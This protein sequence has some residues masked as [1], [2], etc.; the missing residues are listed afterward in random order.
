MVNRNLKMYSGSIYPNIFAVFEELKSK[1]W[2]GF[3]HSAPSFEVMEFSDS[4]IIAVPMPMSPLYRGENEYHE[5]CKPSLYRKEW[6]ELE[7]LKRELLLADFS[8]ILDTHP[9][10][11][12]L[13][14]GGL[15]VN[16]AG[17][18]QHYGIDTHLLDLT[19]SPLVAA[20]FATTEYN[21]L[22]DTYRL[23]TAIQ[24]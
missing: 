7:T 22:S 4:K 1:G 21:P 19:N 6:T 18:A 16:Y 12:E 24:N 23:S 14:K 3:G 11:K 8:K 5:I 15:E 20:F 13:K 10:V 2:N 9:E 17:L